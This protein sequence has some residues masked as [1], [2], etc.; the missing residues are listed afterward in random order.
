MATKGTK[1][2]SSRK[3]LLKNV[4]M[5]FNHCTGEAPIN[6]AYVGARA[7]RILTLTRKV[8]KLTASKGV[9]SAP[10]ARR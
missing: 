9:T 3:A 8:L 10:A 2:G 1:G 7:G 6:P 5:L 4:T